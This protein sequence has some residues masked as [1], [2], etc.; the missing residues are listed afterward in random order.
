MGQQGHPLMSDPNSKRRL[1]DWF[2]QWRAPLRK[3]L[4]GKGAIPTADLD[5]VAQEVFLRLMRYERAELIE[6]PQAYLYKMASNLAAEWA[7]RG[8]YVRPHESK[9]LEGLTTD[10][11]PEN[12]ASQSELQDEVERA[13]LTLAPRQR[14]VLKMQF[15]EGLS[16]VQIAEKIGMSERSVKRT[17]AKSYEMLRVQL[18]ARLLKGITDGRE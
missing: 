10:E 9:W 3:F 15:F 18:D 16:R 12:E 11:Q 8:R 14:E 17:L 2:R 5:D 1:A 4:I 7:I 6:H 13:L